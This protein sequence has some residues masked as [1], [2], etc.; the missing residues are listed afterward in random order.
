TAST[1]R[2]GSPQRKPN[3]GNNSFIA[4]TGVVT[5]RRRNRPA[6]NRRVIRWQNCRR[7]TGERAAGAWYQVLPPAADCARICRALP[8][9]ERSRRRRDRMIAPSRAGLRVRGG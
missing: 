9:R 5:A 1:R 7:Y 8:D 6:T 2:G 3:G 4:T